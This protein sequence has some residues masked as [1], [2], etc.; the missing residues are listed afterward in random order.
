MQNFTLRRNIYKGFYN[1][2]KAFMAD[3]SSNTQTG[4]AKIR[5]MNQ[6]TGTLHSWAVFNRNKP[7]RNVS[8]QAHY[9]GQANKD[10]PK[11]SERIAFLTGKKI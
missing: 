6:S 1:I 8:K 2:R 10:F 3:W 11:V 9:S 7:E 5:G 4:E